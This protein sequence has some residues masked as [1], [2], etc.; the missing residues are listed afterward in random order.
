MAGNF[1][2]AKRI[3]SPERKWHY[4]QKR[5]AARTAKLSDGAHLI[6]Q[7]RNNNK[8]VSLRMIDVTNA[9]ALFDTSTG[10]INAL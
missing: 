8:S 4:R 3:F 6:H 2:G 5:A 1:L 7:A 10:V 9:V